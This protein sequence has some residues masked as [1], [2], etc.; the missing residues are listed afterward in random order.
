[1]TNKNARRKVAFESSLPTKKTAD[2]GN[3]ISYCNMIFT[4]FQLVTSFYGTDF[5]N[6]RFLNYQGHQK[7]ASEVANIFFSMVALTMVM[8]RMTTIQNDLLGRL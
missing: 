5:A 8:I 4:S 1:M 7:M 6:V 2:A 3:W